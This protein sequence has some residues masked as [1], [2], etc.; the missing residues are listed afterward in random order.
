MKVTRRSLLAC[1]AGARLLGASSRTRV[2][3]AGGRWR[4]NGEVTYAGAQ[5]EGLLMNVRMVN[6]VFENANLK[7]RPQGFDPE[8]NTR[9]FLQQVSEY[10][11]HGIRAFTISLQGGDPGYE[12][13]VNSAIAPDGTLRAAYLKRVAAV[14]ETCDRHGAVVILSCFYQRQDQNS[15]G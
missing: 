15:T 1:M 10:V 5:A 11:A 9:R 3:I 7:T 8:A 14:I 6:A 2:D 13:A 12:G 4:L